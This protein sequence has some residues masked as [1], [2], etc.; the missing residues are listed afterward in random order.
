MHMESV[1]GSATSLSGKDLIKIKDHI[2]VYNIVF[3]SMNN[4]FSKIN[5]FVF[6]MFFFSKFSA[7]LSGYISLPP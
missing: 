4:K 7:E 5:L 2:Y 3:K 6:F 1:G